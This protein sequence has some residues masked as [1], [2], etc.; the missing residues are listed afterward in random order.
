MGKRVLILASIAFGLMA[1]SPPAQGAK[2]DVE[3]F[4]PKM[5]VYSPVVMAPIA[6]MATDPYELPVD[7]CSINCKTYTE[8]TAVMAVSPYKKSE[9]GTDGRTIRSCPIGNPC[10]NRTGHIDPGLKF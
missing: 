10:Y 9:Y 7:M 5:R 3:K 2:A 8:V 4:S 1:Y 6:L